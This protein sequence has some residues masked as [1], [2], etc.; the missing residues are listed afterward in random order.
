M[1]IPQRAEA[2]QEYNYKGSWI[3][4]CHAGNFVLTPERRVVMLD[5]EQM[6]KDMNELLN[7]PSSRTQ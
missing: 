1:V 5:T 4:N 6:R 3:Y 7:Q 2:L